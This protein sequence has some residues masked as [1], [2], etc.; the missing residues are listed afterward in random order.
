[1][2]Y[3]M[4]QQQHGEMT[5]LVPVIFPNDL[6]HK[7][8]ADALQQLVLKDTVIH[9]AGSISLLNLKPEGRST[10]LNIEA[11]HDTDELV[12]KMNDYGAGWQ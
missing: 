8:V 1:M 9:S 3:I 7:E 4:F 5:K 2:K 11:D 6:V 12:I 10:T